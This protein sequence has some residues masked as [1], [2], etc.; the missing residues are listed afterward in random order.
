MND[1]IEQIK[2]D[3]MIRMK[4]EEPFA[5]NIYARQHHT[6][7]TTTKLN[8]H[9]VHSLLLIDVLLRMKINLN[10]RKELLDLCY[11]EYDGNPIQ[12]RL[13]REFERTYS[14]KKIL[15]WY[16]RETFLYRILNKALRTQNIDVLFLFHFIISDI[17]RALRENQCQSIVRVYRG[18][19]MSME[20]LNNLRQSKGDFIS[21]NT[22]FSTSIHRT[23]AMR[24]LHR[25]EI[26]SDQCR[27][28]FEI[29]ANP[30]LSS[31]KPFADLSRFSQYV[32]EKEILFMIGCVFRLRDVHQSDH[33]QS[34]WIVHM[35][36]CDD[37]EH[38]MRQLFEHMKKDYGGGND[39]VNTLA[40]GRVLHQMGKYELA[41]KFYRRLLHE[42]P[43]RDPTLS[44]LYYSLGVVLMDIGD[45]DSSL[46]WLNKSLEIVQQ[47]NPSDYVNI[48]SRYC[49]IGLLYSRK[50]DHQRALEQ[51]KQGIELF[52]KRNNTDHLYLAHLY[53][54]KAIVYDEQKRY[55][56]AL[57]CF[58]KT[59]AIY[60]KHLPPDHS[61]VGTVHDNM[62]IIYRVLGDYDSAMKCHEQSMQIR[63]KSLPSDHTLIAFN[64]RNIGLVHE[65]KGDLTDALICLEKAERIY[66]QSFSSDHPDMKKINEDLWR[67]CNKFDRHT[68]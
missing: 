43:L 35:E 7:R 51:Y 29:D 56:K 15:W 55:P 62:G 34:T 14:S 31:S 41:E 46:Q 52:Q 54:N 47:T 57:K 37:D 68:H 13:V 64:Y 6:D 45:Y 61:D 40:F 12:L 39:Q 44:D 2:Q 66:R 10:D 19:I 59:L 67:I 48:S 23:T 4:I 18:Q 24:F 9:F 16:S 27:V 26:L 53:N 32:D 8:G 63:E 11:N 58:R 36:L 42:V 38:D 49:C 65:K 50:H 28:L 3:Q 33:N 30:R 1:L 5:F 22:F 17:E 20:E 60:E 21:I 25:T